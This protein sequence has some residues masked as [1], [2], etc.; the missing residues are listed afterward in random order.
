MLALL[1]WFKPAFDNWQRLRTPEGV[2][3]LFPAF[4]ARSCSQSQSPLGSIH[5]TT[6]SGKLPESCFTAILS[7]REYS[8]IKSCE[9]DDYF[10]DW[11]DEFNR[12]MEITGIRHYLVK[13]TRT[14]GK[15]PR[16]ELLFANHDETIYTRIS[17][18][19]QGPRLV[20]L[21]AVGM[22]QEVSG[23]ACSEYFRS[24]QC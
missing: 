1:N 5:V 21:F 11:R 23:P 9:A 3:V 20:I 24:V 7:I 2:G 17:L 14:D 8:S 10:F 13:E 4:P 16:C 22:L 19:A 15:I 6:Y 18:N 12:T